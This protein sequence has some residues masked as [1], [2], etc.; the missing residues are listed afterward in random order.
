MLTSGDVVD[1]DFGEP[2]GREAGFVRPAVVATAQAILDE[3]PNIVQVIPVTSIDRQF[4]TEI[5]IGLSVANGLDAPSV[6]Q[7]Q[8]IRAVSPDR[9]AATRGNVGP[10]T[11]AQIREL[12]GRVVGLIP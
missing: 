11:L 3:S 9:I 6:A 8:H 10:A 7:C 2:K 5:P 12:I 4:R 1:V